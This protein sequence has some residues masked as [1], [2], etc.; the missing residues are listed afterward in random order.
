[1]MNNP[2]IG[3]SLDELLEEDDLLTKVNEIATKR[4]LAW[5]LEQEIRVQNL[6][7]TEMAERMGTSRAALNRLL[8]PEN[9]SVTL[10]TLD[11]AARVVGKRI[12]IELVDA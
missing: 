12:K 11:R 5:Q 9:S 3:S 2:Y 6:T 7:K 4:V 8:N 1:M 10:D